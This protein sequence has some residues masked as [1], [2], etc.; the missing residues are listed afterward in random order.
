MTSVLDNAGTD[1]HKDSG[2]KTSNYF[3]F[4]KSF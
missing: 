3:C 1:A 2:Y 4:A